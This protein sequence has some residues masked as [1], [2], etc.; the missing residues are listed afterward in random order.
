MDATSHKKKLFFKN[1]RHK[2]DGAKTRVFGTFGKIK[3]YGVFIFN[4]LPKISSIQV[5]YYYV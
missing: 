1:F 5:N 2:L 3:K 4:I